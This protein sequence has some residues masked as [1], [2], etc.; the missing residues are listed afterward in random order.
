MVE[1]SDGHSGKTKSDT[2]N[3][4][5]WKERRQKSNKFDKHSFCERFIIESVSLEMAKPLMN[6]WLQIEVGNHFRPYR[7]LKLVFLMAGWADIFQK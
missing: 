2:L 5:G 6:V 3:S 1:K 4:T 7:G